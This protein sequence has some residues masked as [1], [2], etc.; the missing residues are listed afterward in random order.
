MKDTVVV[1]SENGNR[2]L[3]GVDGVQYKGRKDCL[4]NPQFPRGV[5]PHLWIRG[6]NGIVTAALPATSSH[7]KHPKP[8]FVS[9][10]I[11]VALT[12]FTILLITGNL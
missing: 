11:A 10:A 3:C 12:I 6:E 9:V 7:P 4:I 1:F 5:A 2:I 8:S